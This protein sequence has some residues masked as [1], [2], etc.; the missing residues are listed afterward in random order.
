[1]PRTVH[2]FPLNLADPCT[3]GWGGAYL[4]PSHASYWVIVTALLL[5]SM[6]DA[7]IGPFL[8]PW[9]GLWLPLWCAYGLFLYLRRLA[10]FNPRYAPRPRVV[11]DPRGITL[12]DAFGRIRYQWRWQDLKS[13][14]RHG[15]LK[16]L[17]IESQDGA[18]LDYRHKRLEREYDTYAQIERVAQDYLRG[19]APS[20]PPPVPPGLDYRCHSARLATGRFASLS[21]GSPFAFLV[22][23]FLGKSMNPWAY[24]AAVPLLLQLFYVVAMTLIIA[25]IGALLVFIV[26]AYRAYFYP[27]EKKILVHINCHGI[28]F[29]HT[30]QYL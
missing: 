28:Y 19:M 13:V 15:I 26:R 9:V 29:F 2:R 16:T 10:Y 12:H 27:P 21:C 5:P 23:L 30:L 4:N 22:L 11:C 25:A 24:G 14:R 1:M 20:L 18:V 8:T 3:R 6:Y 17:R 7:T